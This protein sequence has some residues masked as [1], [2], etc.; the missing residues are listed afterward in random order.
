MGHKRFIDTNHRSEWPD[1]LGK[2]KPYASNQDNTYKPIVFEMSEKGSEEA[3]EELAKDKP[4]S[5]IVDNYDEQY[6][7]LLLSRDPHLYT[8]KFEVQKHSIK[9]KLSKHYGDNSS[10]QLG[11]WVYYPWSGVLLHTLDRL[12]FNDLRTI[13]NRDLITKSDQKILQEFRVGCVGMSVGSSAALALALSGISI[14]LKNA[15]GATISGSNLNRVLVGV[16]DVGIE[17]GVAISRKMYEMNPYLNISNLGEKLTRE[18]ISEFFSAPWELDLVVDE[19]DDLE[20]KVMIREEARKRK[21]PVIMATELADD[22]MLDVERFDQNN[23]AD[24][25]HGR[26]G[27]IEETLKTRKLSQREWMKY[28]TTIIGTNN[29]PLE[30]QRSL[31]K[32]GTKVVTHPQ[33]GATAMM[34]GGVITYAIKQIALGKPLPSMRKIISVEKAFNKKSKSL[35]HRRKHKRHTKIIKKTIGS[36]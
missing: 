22:V 24:L 6:A 8:A 17:K 3:L 30:M 1:F 27:K 32:I 13:R 33:L 4:I 23:S 28:A 5:R 7:E 15:D 31:L 18:N 29:V 36:I 25:F 35:S 21:V 10:W 14:N 16:Q 12:H 19:M 34:T 26:V 20:M 2:I 9:H 11:S